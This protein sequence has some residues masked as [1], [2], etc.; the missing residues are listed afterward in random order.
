MIIDISRSS[1]TI[2]SNPCSFKK[3][4]VSMVHTAYLAQLRAAF[5][6]NPSKFEGIREAT[7]I[8]NDPDCYTKI[9]HKNLLKNF[10]KKKFKNVNISTN[11]PSISNQRIPIPPI[12]NSQLDG[13]Q[14]T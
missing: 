12:Q 5:K 1:K 10:L 6:H 8:C 13:R 14:S 9:C 4:S 11:R 7:F 3:F 2:F